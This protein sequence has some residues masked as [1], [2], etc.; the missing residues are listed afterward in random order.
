M[1]ENYRKF[2]LKVTKWQQLQ[3]CNFHQ[4]QQIVAVARWNHPMY[5][6][7]SWNLDWFGEVL[8]PRICQFCL[9]WLHGSDY[10]LHEHL[11]KAPGINAK[12]GFE[13]Y[14]Q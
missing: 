8:T 14:S 9:V 6:A 5:S 7:N 10:F 3:A 1:H 4:C 2:D 13:K 11:A 12:I